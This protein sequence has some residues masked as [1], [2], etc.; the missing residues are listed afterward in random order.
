M[1]KIIQEKKTFTKVDYTEKNISNR[2]YDA[3]VFIDCDFSKCDL[4]N[5]DFIDCKF[6]DCNFSM[7]KFN[8][9]GLKNVSFYGCKL[10]GCDFTRCKDF[11]LSFY[12]EKSSLDFSSFHRKKINNTIFRDCNIKEVDFSHTDLTGSSFLN[13]DL[14]RTIFQQTILEK[15]DFR[16]ANNFFFDL[17]LN[18]IKKAK[19]SSSGVIGLLDKYKIIIE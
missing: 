12:F 11:L 1:N 10:L 4:T 7:V 17:E 14:S 9:T 2:E 3:C 18:K 15:A 6:E 13:C 5:I 19:F 8:N 16:T